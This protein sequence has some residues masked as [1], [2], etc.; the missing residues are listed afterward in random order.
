MLGNLARKL[1][2]MGYDTAYSSS[3]EDNDLIKKAKEENRII[4]SKDEQLIKSAYKQNIS[5][6][7]IK[8]IKEID[9]TLEVIEKLRLKKCIIT[10]ETTRCPICNGVLNPVT[11][12]SIMDKIPQK[13]FEKTKKFWC[14]SNC[15]KIYWEG[16]HII[17][18]QKFVSEINE[19]LQSIE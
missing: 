11:P 10:A 18:M 13:V 17:N 7:E 9:Q 6:I 2:L 1:R 8:Q 12:N 19:R 14:C 3:I 4:I 16:T 5:S 15:D